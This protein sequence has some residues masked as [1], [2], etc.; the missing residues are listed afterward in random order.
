M[1]LK[2]ICRTIILV[3]ILSS[4]TNANSLQMNQNQQKLNEKN[5]LGNKMIYE[6]KD[7]SK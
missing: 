7:T 3:I 4:F 5:S 2:L 1:P 6:K